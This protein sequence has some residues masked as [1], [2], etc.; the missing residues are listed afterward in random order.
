MNDYVIRGRDERICPSRPWLHISGKPAVCQGRRSRSFYP[1]PVNSFAQIHFRLDR[2][3][4]SAPVRP[5]AVKGGAAVYLPLT[6]SDQTGIMSK[7]LYILG[8]DMIALFFS[9]SSWAAFPIQKRRLQV[10]TSLPHF[11]DLLLI[12]C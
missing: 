11:L 5:W 7:A 6:A 10:T 9:R 4:S 1:G 12:L 2:L 8:G 3:G